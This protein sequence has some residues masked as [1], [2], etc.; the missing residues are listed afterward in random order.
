MRRRS[1]GRLPERDRRD[2]G[3]AGKAVFAANCASC[4]WSE[5]T[6]GHPCSTA[7]PDQHRHGRSGGRSRHRLERIKSWN[8]DAAIRSNEVV[9][10]LRHR[11]QGSGGSGSR[12]A[13]SPPSSTASGCARRICTT[14]RCRR[15]ATCS[16]RRTQRPQ[17]FYRGY[18]VYDT[19][20]G[21]FIS[22]EAQ[23][24]RLAPGW[25]MSFEDLR[26]SCERSPHH[27]TSTRAPTAT[28]DMSTA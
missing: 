25:K 23:A 11:A 4:H 7:R 6:T 3:R 20:N 18:D 17:L 26:A 1:S 12:P 28:W 5:Q 24:Q 15:C 21:G 27:T 2:E 19:V 10:D 22:T 16:S 9:E 8:K 13:T 14:A